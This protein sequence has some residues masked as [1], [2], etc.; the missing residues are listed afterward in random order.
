V[1]GASLH[2]DTERPLC[3]AVK[4]KP[5]LPWRLQDAGDARVYR[6]P[7]EESF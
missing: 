2:G 4:V 3:E 7:A 1:A 6:I 5:G